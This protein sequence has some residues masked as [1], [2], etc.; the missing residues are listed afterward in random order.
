MERPYHLQAYSPYIQFEQVPQKGAWTIMSSIYQQGVKNIEIAF[1]PTKHLP[2]LEAAHCHWP[3]RVKYMVVG[4]LL[5]LPL[6]QL[7]TY[8]ALRYFAKKIQI[9]DSDDLEL[10][11]AKPAQVI[12]KKVE[13]PAPAPIQEIEEIEE[14]DVEK[15]KEIPLQSIIEQ[16][17]E[18]IFKELMSAKE[19]REL[20]TIRNDAIIY[21]F[22]LQINDRGEIYTIKDADFPKAETTVRNVPHKRLYTFNLRFLASQKNTPDRAFQLVPQADQVIPPN[23]Q[24]ALE[25]FTTQL[26]DIPARI[27]EKLPPMTVSEQAK[28]LEEKLGK[29]K[30][31]FIG[32]RIILAREP[33]W[34]V[35]L[36][37]WDQ[38]QHLF[39]KQD[40]KLKEIKEVVAGE[41]DQGAQIVEQN[42]QFLIKDFPNAPTRRSQ[43]MFALSGPNW[44]IYEFELQVNDKGEIYRMQEA[45]FE[46]S[47]KVRE[48]EH[49]TLYKIEF[50]CDFRNFM[51]LDRAFQYT[52]PEDVKV[53][54]E[55]FQMADDLVTQFKNTAERIMLNFS[56]KTTDEQADWLAANLQN[57]INAV[58][59]KDM[60]ERQTLW[61]IIF[62]HW[63]QLQH[64][65]VEQ[66]A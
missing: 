66:K 29:E 43:R 47:I 48:V 36:R 18:T 32:W 35:I 46:E 45:L 24:E 65:F 14:V 15:V 17:I 6:V 25:D 51:P 10:I 16:N 34:S 30:N 31:D 23:L 56:S 4:A 60:L 57:G 13:T 63:D 26:N 20:K 64:L 53:H 52:M 8:V 38:L 39:V 12:N 2:A 58:S 59:Y 19:R 42:M 61:S 1:C 40:K 28:W 49:A 7:V 33:L 50:K 41:E 5:C 62:H 27:M 37:H 44:Y 9:D 3:Q 55:V 11:D 22:E 21:P 54:L